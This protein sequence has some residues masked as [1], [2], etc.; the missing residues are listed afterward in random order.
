LEQHPVHARSGDFVV[1]GS[2]RSFG[3]DGNDALKQVTHFIR[4]M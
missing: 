1:V 4:D 3:G 2:G